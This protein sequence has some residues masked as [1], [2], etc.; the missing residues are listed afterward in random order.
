MPQTPLRPPT[1]SKI[2][3]LPQIA[4]WPRDLNLGVP[5]TRKGKGKKP[6]SSCQRDS[7]K[8]GVVYQSHIPGKMQGFQK[9]VVKTVKDF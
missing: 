4:A 8:P 3:L 1:C 5:D 9:I 6:G 7:R 2:A